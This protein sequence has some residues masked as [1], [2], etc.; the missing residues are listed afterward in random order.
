MPTRFVVERFVSVM[1]LPMKFEA[2]TVRV[3]V[4]LFV[5]KRR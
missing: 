4:A 3:K 2:I 5:S 1:P